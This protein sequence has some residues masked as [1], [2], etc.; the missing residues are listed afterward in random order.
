MQVSVDN[1]D[2]DLYGR[3]IRGAM[4]QPSDQAND[5][6]L[7]KAHDLVRAAYA[8]AL[9][10]SSLPSSAWVGLG[11]GKKRIL[12]R[13]GKKPAFIGECLTRNLLQ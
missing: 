3:E 6:I 8:D 1:I 7:A 5:R 2:T 13:G 9:V 10:R 4:F 12:D 11:L